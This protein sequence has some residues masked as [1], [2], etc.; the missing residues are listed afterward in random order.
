MANLSAF[1]RITKLQKILLLSNLNCLQPTSAIAINTALKAFLHTQQ[2][3]QQQQQPS[4]HKLTKPY[5]T[6]LNS[7]S[8]QFTTGLQ[9]TS[10]STTNLDEFRAQE[11]KREK[12][13]NKQQNETPPD[14]KEQEDA[15]KA[16]TDGVR[17]KILDAA[18]KHVPI[19]GWSRQAIVLGAQEAGYPSEVHGMFPSGG[20]ELVSHFVAKCN[21]ALLKHMQAET[22]NG[23]KEV[24]DPLDFLIRSV[25]F[26]LQMIEPYKSH[27]P[28]AMALIALP[29]NVPTSLAQV[30]TMVDDMCYYSG[31]RSVDFGWYT[32]RVGLATIFK[33]VEVFMLQ[34]KSP[35]HQETWTFL[36]N[37]MEEA[38]QIQMVLSQT[39][40][41]T[42][43]FQR[44]F[45]SAFVT[46]RNILGLNYNRR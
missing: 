2:Q 7:L 45:N 41:M 9:N 35:E 32:R 24:A 31:D 38:A 29:P 18:L 17:I 36:K 33:M 10:K 5:C 42:H 25:K 34:D 11:E 37:R 3:Q 26:R 4:S 28:Q 21:N 1:N 43:N 23:Q 8:R 13:F 30:L 40:D 20:Y 27:W 44:S 46:A 15:R 12:E 22:N 14:E 16:K 39:G 6:Q 19:E